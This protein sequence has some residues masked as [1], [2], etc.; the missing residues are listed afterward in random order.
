MAISSNLLK[1]LKKHK[2]KNGDTI[3]YTELNNSNNTKTPTDIANELYSSFNS[4][5]TKDQKIILEAIFDG[6][7]DIVEN[8]TKNSKNKFGLMEPKTKVF[9]EL[10]IKNNG[11]GGL[12]FKSLNNKVNINITINTPE[13]I[14]STTN[15][16]TLKQEN[17]AL[18]SFGVQIIDKNLKSEDF[19]KLAEIFNNMSKSK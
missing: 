12:D 18:K 11:K 10:E 19:A 14:N 8:S 2:F 5:N 3:T 7:F 1:Q 6:V 16:Q 13:V 4:S 9:A 15:E 17:E